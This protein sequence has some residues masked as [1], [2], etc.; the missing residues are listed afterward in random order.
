MQS[1]RSAH[2]VRIALNNAAVR[3]F[4]QLRNVCIRLYRFRNQNFA[5]SFT[6]DLLFHVAQYIV[7]PRLTH[8][9]ESSVIFEA[10]KGTRFS[11]NPEPI[12]P[13][14]IKDGL[15]PQKKKPAR[16][17]VGIQSLRRVAVEAQTSRTTRG[18]NTIRTTEVRYRP[19]AVVNLCTAKFGI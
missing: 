13:D 3:P 7:K 10:Q 1:F 14:D 8:N 6:L 9:Q 4:R 18:Q 16:S 11:S 17:Q 19:A 2:L 15:P 12:A 5:L